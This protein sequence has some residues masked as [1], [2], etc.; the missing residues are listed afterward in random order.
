[1]TTEWWVLA[2]D[3]A[4]ETSRF[5]M[6]RA[7]AVR[8]AIAH[9]HEV[10]EVTVA[11]AL[12]ARSFASR[13]VGQGRLE[14][15]ELLRHAPVTFMSALARINR[16]RPDV[17]DSLL[18][19]AVAGTLTGDHLRT[20]EAAA[21]AEYERTLPRVLHG[22][23]GAEPRD[24]YVLRSRAKNFR[25][26][27]LGAL[28]NAGDALPTG[29]LI[30]TVP[31]LLAFPLVV[32]AV[33]MIPG[34]TEVSFRGIR[35]YPAAA[36]DSDR[37]RLSWALLAGS[38][39][40]RVFHEYLAVFE[41]EEDAWELSGMLAEFGALGFGVAFLDPTD[42]LHLVRNADRIAPPDLYGRFGDVFEHLFRRAAG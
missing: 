20:R 32:T 31:K 25:D 18:P 9:K 35:T 26:R 38:L 7:G 40:S 5:G 15:E 16:Y 29:R 33:A 28:S 14:R 19:S 36:A 23:L 13:L 11:R 1:M 21:Q 12:S 42:H 30:R 34:V 6:G 27:A 17:V 4:E 37:K 3:Y 39:A 22:P 24:G 2:A 41:Q 10:S 8:Q